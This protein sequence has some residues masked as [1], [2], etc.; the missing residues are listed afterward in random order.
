[1]PMTS[2]HPTELARAAEILAQIARLQKELQE[3]LHGRAGVA[4]LE[5]LAE[6][7]SLS[8]GWDSYDAEPP[9]EIA[10]EL[11]ETLLGSLEQ[12]AL[13][14]AFITPTSDSSILVKHAGHDS[15]VTWEIDPDGEIGVMV[16]CPGAAPRFLSPA[17]GEIGALVE[18]LARHG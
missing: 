8:K 7:R 2:E 14:V 16:E 13:P 10:C 6:I 4:H 9:S 17:T 1:M 3:V 18:D 15:A 11:A 12:H 5:K